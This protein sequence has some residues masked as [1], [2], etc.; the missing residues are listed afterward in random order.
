MIE[1]EQAAAW[2]ANHPEETGD[3]AY[4]AQ[5]IVDLH[6]EVADLTTR[7]R[8]AEASVAL[9]RADL[10]APDDLHPTGR[11]R[12]GGEGRCGWCLMNAIR[13]DRDAVRAELD[14]F[15]AFHRT[16]TDALALELR[17]LRAAEAPGTDDEALAPWE[18]VGDEDR[19]IWRYWQAPGRAVLVS[20]GAGKWSHFD[21]KKWTYDY[22]LAL[23]A[24]RA[25][26]TGS[27]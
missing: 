4:M 13:E 16:K 5:A 2:L 23:D 15:A 25:A 18:S 26:V 24:M 14:T 12:C 21:G 8:L 20:R 3:G 11:C 9:L 10:A 27:V 6:D 19:P 17:R 7:L 22:D 1:K